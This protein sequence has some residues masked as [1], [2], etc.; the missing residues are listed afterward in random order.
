MHQAPE[1]A[2]GLTSDQCYAAILR[3]ERW[4]YV[5]FAGLEPLLFDMAADPTESRNL[6]Q[7]PAHQATLLACAQELLSFRMVHADRTLAGKFLTAQG[8]V[9]RADP[10]Y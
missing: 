2:L 10:R 5:H 6:A 4:K 1:Q 7:D 3:G 9:E 8:V